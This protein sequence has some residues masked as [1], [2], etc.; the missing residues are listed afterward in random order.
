MRRTGFSGF[1]WDEGNLAKCQ[2]HGL[3]IDEIEHVLAHAET[4]IR[5]APENEKRE[6]RFLAIG[7]TQKGRYAFVV[8]T[9][10]RRTI[11]LRLR[12]ISAR[13]MHRREIRK[14]EQEIART[15]NR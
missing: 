12:P 9:P 5:P 11:G 2:Q 8:F 3:S 4:L 13:Y 6:T 1:D 10:R 14:Y 7:R 15:Q